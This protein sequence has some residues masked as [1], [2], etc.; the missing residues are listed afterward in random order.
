V[1]FG[2]RLHPEKV[3]GKYLTDETIGKEKQERRTAK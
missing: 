3:R 2:D 1:R